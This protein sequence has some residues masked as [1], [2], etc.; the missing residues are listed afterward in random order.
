MY[1]VCIPIVGSVYKAGWIQCPSIWSNNALA[2]DFETLREVRDVSLK[3]LAAARSKNYIGNS[4]EAEIQIHTD[5]DK[6]LGII[7]KNMSTKSTNNYSLADFL[8]VSRVH[9]GKD[10]LTKEVEFIENEEVMCGFESCS[11]SV[12]VVKAN[13]LKCERCWQHVVDEGKGDL[14]ARCDSVINS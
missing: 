12:G 14:C 1:N 4:L 8:I 6:L 9:T 7:E 3:S 5:S 11:V 10:A 13:R 2:Q